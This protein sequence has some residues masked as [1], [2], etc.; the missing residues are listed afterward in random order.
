MKDC[1]FQYALESGIILEN[2]GLILRADA[3]ELWQK[4][5]QVFKQH[6]TEGKNPEMA[7]WID[8]DNKDDFKKTCAHW[9]GADFEVRDGKMYNLIAVC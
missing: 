9:H 8:M 2:T 4:Y 5:I 1:V 6:V 3:E 7:I